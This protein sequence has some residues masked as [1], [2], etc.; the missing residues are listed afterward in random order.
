MVDVTFANAAAAYANGA[1]S[2]LGA[3]GAAS[4]KANAGPSFA[5]MI[6]DALEGARDAGLAAES[7]TIAAVKG[8]ANLHDVVAAVS[9]AEVTLQ[10]VVAVRDRVI[11]AYQEIMRMPI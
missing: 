1:T 10:T 2:A 6:G 5:E 4:A 9:N 3:S 7:K 11:S 8:E